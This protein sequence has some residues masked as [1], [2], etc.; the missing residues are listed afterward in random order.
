MKRKGIDDELRSLYSKYWPELLKKREAVKGPTAAGAMV[1][2]FGDDYFATATKKIV[3]CGQE[4][5]EWG[6]FES[7]EQSMDMYR[8]FFVNEKFYKGYL[9]SSFWKTFRAIKGELTKSFPDE[10]LAFV[11]Q[12][13]SKIG[14]RH[15]K[16]MTNELRALEREYFPVV[17]EE[18]L[19]I[20]PDIFIFM[21]GPNRDGDIKFHF[22][23]AEFHKCDGEKN[24]RRLAQI[25]SS[26]LPTASFRVYH[27]TYY[28]AWT[29][30]YRN[31][32]IKTIKDT[33]SVS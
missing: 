32:L 28:R 8:E 33:E 18:T 20:K 27:P 10:K 3:I 25:S 31:R 30:E 22:K 26:D 13:I 5:K 7:I 29:Y 14:L 17:L 23:D 15:D 12:N 6:H 19:I 2:A 16:G 11:Y 9:T 1:L 21:T 4:T 24:L